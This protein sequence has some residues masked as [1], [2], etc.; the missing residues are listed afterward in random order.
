MD[1]LT[2]STGQVRHRRAFKALRLLVLTPTIIT[3]FN[4]PL[5]MGIVKR[6]REGGDGRREGGKRR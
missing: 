4:T 2:D 3:T 5:T 1:T 6:G